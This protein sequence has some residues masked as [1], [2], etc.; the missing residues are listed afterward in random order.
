MKVVISGGGELGLLFLKELSDAHDLYVIEPNPGMVELLEE[1]DA[2]IIQGNPTDLSILKSAQTGESDYF[3][4]CAHSDEV[5]VIASLAA[6]QLGKAITFCFVNKDHYFETFLGELGQHLV[7]DHLIWPE[8]LLVEDITRIISVPE[9]VDVEVIEKDVLKLLEFP[10]KSEGPYAGKLVRELNLPPGVLMVA[11]V[12]GREVSIPGGQTKLEAGDKVI[13]IGIQKSMRQIERRFAP[14]RKS[15]QE[16]T[17]VGGGIVGFMLAKSL[18]E[19]G[20][21][22]IKIIESSL[23]KCQSIAAQLPEDVLVLNGDGADIEFLQANQIPES[24]C[25]VAMTE[26]DEK[27]LLISLLAKQMKVSKVITRVKKPRNAELFEKVGI[28]VSLSSRSTAVKNVIQRVNSQGINLM[29][30]IEEG[31]AEILEV[32]VPG[33][34]KA[35]PLMELKLPEGVLIAAIRRSAHTIVPH[36]GDRIKPGDRLRIFATAGKGPA[37]RAFFS[38]DGPA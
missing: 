21:L 17:I 1:F 11:V 6:K 30:V 35:A 19:V 16:V 3:I 15:R 4:A 8:K 26:T 24:E 25:L 34:F 9:A 5:N 27:N 36:G 22:D 28:D 29:T 38:P 23:P 31:K 33:D 7:I 14:S 18:K 37:V 13:F 32:E 12:R 2:Q 10:L 20:N